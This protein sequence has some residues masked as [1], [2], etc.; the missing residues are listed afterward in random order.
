VL[1]AKGIARQRGACLIIAVSADAVFR[2][3]VVGHTGLVVEPLTHQRLTILG[4]CG[5]NGG[6]AAVVVVANQGDNCDF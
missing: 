5:E 1:E 6:G 3:I 2:L 4:S